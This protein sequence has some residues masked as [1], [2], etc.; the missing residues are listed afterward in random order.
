MPAESSQL[1]RKWHVVDVKI[2]Q[3]FS[4]FRIIMN[5]EATNEF[6]D[7]GLDAVDSGSSFL[8]KQMLALRMH[9]ILET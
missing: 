9:Q 2:Y 7:S 3:P 4:S 6:S 8:L 1:F 5:E